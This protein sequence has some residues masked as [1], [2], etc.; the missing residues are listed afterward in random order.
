MDFVAHCQVVDKNVAIVAV[1]KRFNKS[2]GL[3]TVLL[4]IQLAFACKEMCIRDRPKPHGSSP[5]VSP[6]Q[7]MQLFGR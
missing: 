5:L 4:N 3:I 1:E 6:I 2:E 7:H